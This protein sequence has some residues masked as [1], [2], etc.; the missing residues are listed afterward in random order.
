MPC[1]TDYRNMSCVGSCRALACVFSL[2]PLSSHLFRYRIFI[3]IVVVVIVFCHYCRSVRCGARRISCSVRDDHRDDSYRRLLLL[4]TVLMVTTGLVLSLLLSC[5][6]C[7]FHACM[8]ASSCT[9]M[10]MHTLSSST[11]HTRVWRA[12]YSVR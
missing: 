9:S 6:A 10:L 12:I 1:C 11:S 8:W 4:P 5:S 3:F 2:S 7:S